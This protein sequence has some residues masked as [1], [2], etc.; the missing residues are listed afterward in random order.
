MTRLRW[1]LTPISTVL[2]VFAVACGGASDDESGNT[3]ATGSGV[4]SGSSASPPRAQ[5]GGQ[6]AANG[7]LNVANVASSLEAI[8]S[9]RFDLRLEM[10]FDGDGGSGGDAEAA[11]MLMALLGN[12]EAEG[13]YLAPDSYEMSMSFFGMEV[14]IVQIG[15]E[16][17]TNDGSGWVAGAG[18]SMPFDMSSP[19]DLAFEFIPLAELAGAETSSENVN[20]VETTRYSFDKE[21]L[22]ALAE[23]AGESTGIEDLSEVDT[24]TLDVWLTSDGVPVKLQMAVQG[25]SDGAHVSV[26]MEL[27]VTDLNDSSITI[28]RPI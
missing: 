15:D 12:I 20:G 27:N 21:S 25:E 18:L 3:D 7:T 6:T 14:Q 17:W 28:E 10:D 24:M 11:A 8:E 23:A 1:L 9:F 4:A 16:V 2:L 19:A 5:T 13:A 22:A 26:K